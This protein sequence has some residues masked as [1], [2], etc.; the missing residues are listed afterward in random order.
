MKP[1]LAI[2][3]FPFI[4][5]LNLYFGEE[6]EYL[7]FKQRKCRFEIIKGIFGLH[8]EAQRCILTKRYQ[9]QICN[10][11][12]VIRKVALYF[13]D[14]SCEV[15]YESF[16]LRC[17]VKREDVDFLCEQIEEH[18]HNYRETVFKRKEN[19]SRH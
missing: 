7:R 12:N 8:Q 19:F 3:L 2:Y 4:F 10:T 16:K 13:K 1:L 18:Y 17:E 6:K 11:K 5:N 9:K 15:D 14:S